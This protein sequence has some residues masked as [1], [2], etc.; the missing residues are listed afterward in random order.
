[1]EKQEIRAD[2]AVTTRAP[3]DDTHFDLDRSQMSRL[4]LT[5]LIAVVL[6]VILAIVLVGPVMG[7]FGLQAFG[8]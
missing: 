5:L 4:A 1:M 2:Y 3:E 8:T 7:L 6:A